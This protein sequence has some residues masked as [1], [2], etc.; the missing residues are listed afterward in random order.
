MSPLSPVQHPGLSYSETC[1]VPAHAPPRILTALGPPQP[2]RIKMVS[3]SITIWRGQR[4]AF[5]T[6]RDAKRSLALSARPPSAGRTRLQLLGRTDAAKFCLPRDEEWSWDGE[7]VLPG[8]RQS[9]MRGSPLPC[10]KWLKNPF[11]LQRR[12]ITLPE[13]EPN[14]KG[15]D[16]PL[17]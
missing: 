8:P 9:A 3:L 5:Q 6:G 15:L 10:P 11:L 17:H 12:A 16:T 7:P 1:A 4:T 14:G 13:A 2:P